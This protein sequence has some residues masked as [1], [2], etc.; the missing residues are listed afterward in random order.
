MTYAPATSYQ[1]L[2][3]ENDMLTES[4][5]LAVPRMPEITVGTILAGM[6]YNV[7]QLILVLTSDT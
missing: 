2:R 3:Q 7:G 6:F 1:T 5:C 4:A